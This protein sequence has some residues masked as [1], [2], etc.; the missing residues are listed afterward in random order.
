[1]AREQWSR[2]IGVLAATGVLA[3]G[4]P[5]TVSVTGGEGFGGIESA[6]WVVFE[7]GEIETH[8]FL[9]SSVSGYCNKLQKAQDDSEEASDAL[10]EALEDLDPADY[11][12]ENYRRA[13]CEAHSDYYRAAART[14]VTLAPAGSRT[15]Q[16]TLNHPIE[17]EGDQVD[18]PREGTYEIGPDAD[19]EDGT[20]WLAVTRFDGNLY[21]P[22]TNPNV[23]CDAYAEGN[24]DGYY[25]Y[26]NLPF[27]P[28]TEEYYEVTDARIVRSGSLEME[29]G[30]NDDKWKVD[31][32]DAQL[33]D[34]G[35]RRD[36]ELTIKGT[37]TRCDIEISVDPPEYYYR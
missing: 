23:D 17:N 24:D 7:Q 9:F 35:G 26:Y 18:T 13:W 25:Y 36:G 5:A 6:A 28:T 33:V 37:F 4:C 15:G 2:R 22:Y 34:S 31:M 1:M 32:Q 12:S 21:G 30:N 3:A 10:E 8:R 11:D 14:N 16:L 29:A 20:F 19:S 27:Y